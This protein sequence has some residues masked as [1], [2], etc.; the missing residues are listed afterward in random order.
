MG[1]F[2]KKSDTETY[3]AIT[4]LDL[5][6]DGSM[7][8]KKFLRLFGKQKVFYTTPFGDHVDGGNRLFLIPGPDKTGYFPVFSSLDRMKE[9]YELAGRKGYLVMQGTFSDVLKTTRSTNRSDT[10]VKMGVIIDPRYYDVTVD[11]MKLDMV[12]GIV[13]GTGFF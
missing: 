5:H 7:D 8:D 4:L 6:K 1:F 11:A 3:D 12:I 13:D 2:K 10:P 9:H